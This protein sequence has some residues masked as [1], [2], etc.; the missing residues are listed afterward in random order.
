MFIEL[1]NFLNI[2]ACENEQGSFIGVSESSTDGSFVIHHL[3]SRSLKN[4]APVC[5]VALCQSFGHYNA[6]SQKIG[7]N[8]ASLRESNKL[9]FIEGLKL[10]G[11]MCCTDCDKGDNSQCL[12]NTA[13]V[14]KDVLQSVRSKYC[15]LHKSNSQPPLVII[16]NISILIS[17]GFSVTDVVAC[18]HYL[19]EFVHQEHLKKGSLILYTNNGRGDNDEQLK[20]LWNWICHNASLTIEV[21]GLST[22]YC[23][24]VHGEVI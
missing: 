17:L 7:N 16:D 18:C 12:T 6:I 13:R 19:Q 24:D 1:N 4:S 21:S 11:H 23:K 8:L 15:E 2:K 20:I 14:L 9:C 10:L 22:G 5:F 3:L